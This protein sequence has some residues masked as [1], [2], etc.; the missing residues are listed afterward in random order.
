M[1]TTKPPLTIIAA[2]AA[3]LLA[4]SCANAF[5]GGETESSGTTAQ[6]PAEDLAIPSSWLT[7]TSDEW[8]HTE[9]FG[10][11]DA[12]SAQ[13]DECHLLNEAPD[14]LGYEANI[15]RAAWGGFGDSADNPEAY[16]HICQLHSPD[17]YA[18]AIALIQG[19]TPE[20]IQEFVE[21][22]LDQPD[23]PEQDNDVVSL[24]I[25]GAEIHALERWYPTNPSPHGAYQAIFHD[26]EADA[27]AYLEVN[28]LY[29][30]DFDDYSQELIAEDLISLL[31]SAGD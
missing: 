25:D 3:A 2:V 6:E 17:N 4:S 26:S 12:F 21:G 31:R 29:D 28:S 19:A 18:G 11:Y 27:A 22:F 1:R 14:L 5:G 10:S 30:E 13:E 20:E 23:I 15:S 8:P 9:G 16:R 24:E 7:D